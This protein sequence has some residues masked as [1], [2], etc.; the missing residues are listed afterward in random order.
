MLPV[1]IIVSSLTVLAPDELFKTLQVIQDLN[2]SNPTQA[3][4][5]YEAALPKLPTQPSKGIYELHRAGLEAAIKTNDTVRIHEIV[6]LFSENA[7]W[8]A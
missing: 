1:L 5:V 8:L 7:E 3:T 4:R 2:T 6:A